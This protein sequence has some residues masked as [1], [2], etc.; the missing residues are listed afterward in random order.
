[1]PRCCGGASC[2]CAMDAGPHIVIEGTGAPG[3]PFVVIGDVDLEVTDT[4]T[5]DLT[6][7][8]PGTA[9]A[10]WV[11][12][13]KFATTS[14][15][16]D[17]GDVTVAPTNGQVLAWNTS[18]GEWRAVN[19]TTTPPAAILT[20]ASMSGDG[21]AGAPL[22]TR[23]DPNRLL[24]TTASGL[25]LSDTGINATVRHF[26]TTTTRAAAS[27]TP[28]PNTLSTLDS[29]PGQIDYWTG[30]AW[31]PAGAVSMNMS[32]PELYALSGSYVAGL[33]TVLMVRNLVTTTDDDG[34]FDVLSA[35]DL[36]GRAGVLSAQVTPSTGGQPLGSGIPWVPVIAGD[37]G[38]IRAVAYRV[39]DGTVLASAPV[40]ASV[41]ALLY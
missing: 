5:V 26:E 32:G 24:A 22:Q 18:L 15:L 27:P 39:D 20:D 28:T 1:M 8:G 36:T 21:S 19:P 4:S 30:S 13:G 14:K 34:L 25:G 37:S 31:A 23:E 17:L 10:P 2:A 6:L 11:L 41:V 9:D 35:T 12:S 29:N 7:S 40:A 38:A 16:N 33:R 3:D